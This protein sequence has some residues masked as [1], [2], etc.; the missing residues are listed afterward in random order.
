MT[1]ASTELL[2]ELWPLING[3]KWSEPPFTRTKAYV[4]AVLSELTYWH[5]PRWELK[6]RERIKVVPSGTYQELAESAVAEDAL[7]R[8]LREIDFAAF[9]IARPRAVVLV[10]RATSVVFVAIRG[11]AELYDWSINLQVPRVPAGPPSACFH[12]GFFHAIEDCFEDLSKHLAQFARELPIYVTGHSLG[13]AMAAILHAIWSPSSPFICTHSAYTYGM[14][15]YANQA[16]ANAFR[17][18]HH[19]LRER[20]IV[21]RVPPRWL[22]YANP[23][24]EY[25]VRGSPKIRSESIDLGSFATWTAN[26][27]TATAVRD[28]FIEG[29]RQ[30]VKP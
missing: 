1:R 23:R 2:R 21:P 10:L 3:E 17:P 20:D 15:R 14:P 9:V 12:A 7:V 22:G 11:T 5:I 27:V 24:T 6:N 29:Y 8:R 4:C 25:D 19:I 16:A 18:P 13:G 26:L 30:E 28:H